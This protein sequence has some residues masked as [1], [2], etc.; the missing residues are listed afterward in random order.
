M[1]YDAVCSVKSQS[2]FRRNMSPPYIVS[3]FLLLHKMWRRSVGQSVLVSST[4]LGPKTR[5][6][7]LS[8]SCVFVDVG[9]SLCRVCR[10]QLLLAFTTTVIFG[11]ESHGIHDHILLFHIRDSPNLK[12]HV[13]LFISPRNRVAQLYPQA[14][15][16]LYVAS[17]D[18]QGNGGGIRTC[19]HAGVGKSIPFSLYTVISPRTAQ[20]TPLPT[21]PLLCGYSL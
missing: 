15:G 10:L 17:Y 3:V 9:R 4:H 18:S 14:L 2:T 12:G 1:G 13:T 21:I 8:D 5:F 7:L 11:S 6:L 16:Y 20:N 19:P